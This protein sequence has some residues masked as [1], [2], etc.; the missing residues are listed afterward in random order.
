MSVPTHRAPRKQRTSLRLVV[1]VSVAALALTAG[2]SSTAH[3]DD[4]AVDNDVIQAGVQ[5]SVDLTVAPGAP[6]SASAQMVADWQGSKHL[7]PGTTLTIGVAGSSDYDGVTGVSV[8]DA[9]ASVPDPWTSATP[10]FTLSSAISFNAPATPGTYNLVIHY[11]ATSYSC[12]SGDDKCLSP[13]TGDPFLINLTV[14]SPGATNT[15]PSVSFSSPPTNADE[16]TETTFDFAITDPDNG[17]WSFASGYPDCG[18]GTLASGASID[19]TL[20][21]GSFACTF[22]D[23]VVPPVDDAVKLRVSDS[24][25]GTS[26]EV[27][28]LVTVNNVA[29]TV[30]APAFVST[31]VDCRNSVTLGGISFSDP[32]VIDADWTIS[33]DWGDG[34][35]EPDITAGTQGAQGNV[36]HT[37]NAPGSY[38]ATVAV[39]DKDGGEGSNTSSNQVTVNQT[40]TVDFLPPFDDSSPSGLIVN[41]MKN[42]RV[43]PVKATIYDDCAQAFVTDPAEN[44]TIRTSKTSGTGT[45]DPI[46]TYAD[47][48]QSASSTNQFRWSTDGFWIYNLDSK[49]LGLIVGNNYRVDIYVDAVRATTDTWAV[50]QPVK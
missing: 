45:G 30:E 33:I 38:T 9:V 19:S 44:V 6:V 4:V 41:K 17:P 40:Y 21:T 39:T 20:M 13:G 11:V 29:P 3:A 2:I 22:P 23:G 12:D 27:S 42:G 1:G 31:S 26:A 48:G 35:T 8:G 16:G 43:V 10:N 14:E 47:A 5:H 32:G 25:G 36:S 46:E 50:L 28:T 15:A 18:S 37:Y 49:A 7:V 24:A 34:N